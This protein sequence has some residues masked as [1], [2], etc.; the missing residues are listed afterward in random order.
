MNKRTE[1]AIK[2]WL[3]LLKEDRSIGAIDDRG[4]IISYGEAAVEVARFTLRSII[5][6]RFPRRK[7]KAG[8]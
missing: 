4:T 7:K 1:R 5:A 2:A 8:K 6:K 3:A